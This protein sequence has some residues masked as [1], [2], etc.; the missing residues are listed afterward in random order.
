MPLWPYCFHL[1]VEGIRVLDAVPIAVIGLPN[2][3]GMGCPASRSNSGL[4]SNRSRWLGPPSMNSQ[5]T[6]FAVGG[7]S[8]FFGASG[9]AGSAACIIEDTASAPSPPQARI[10]KARRS[11]PNTCSL[12]LPASGSWLL[13][14]YSSRYLIP[15]HKLIRV[16]Q[17][18][19]KI[20]ERRGGRGLDARRHRHRER[21][22]RIRSTG[23]DHALLLF[24][25]RRRRVLFPAIRLPRIREPERHRSE[26]RRVGKECRSRW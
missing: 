14:S 6:H 8:V 16:Q 24:E 20:H 9:S 12:I 17:H 25:E 15:I 5:M 19:A 22:F 1:R 4:G 11:T 7:G 2:D 23:G 13:T 26:E 18:L 3:A 10:R 21:Q